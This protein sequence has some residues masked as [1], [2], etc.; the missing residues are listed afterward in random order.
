LK[1][2]PLL[3][4]FGVEGQAPEW[5]A[6]QRRPQLERVRTRIPAAASPTK[7]ERAPGAGQAQ[8]DSPSRQRQ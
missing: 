7:S 3:H 5:G 8:D 1:P 6:C 2:P 4:Q